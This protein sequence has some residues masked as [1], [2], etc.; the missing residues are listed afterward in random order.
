MTLK[1][2]AR[3]MDEVVVLFSYP[4]DEVGNPLMAR[5]AYVKHKYDDA[6]SYDEASFVAVPAQREAGVIKCYAGEKE[7]TG[8]VSDSDTS[9]GE[10]TEIARKKKLSAL[11][12]LE[13]QKFIE[14]AVN[15]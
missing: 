12:A 8:N 11:I 10:E 1:A 5:A 9:G 14:E 13:D 4:N 2:I 15:T 6:G 7:G 3:A